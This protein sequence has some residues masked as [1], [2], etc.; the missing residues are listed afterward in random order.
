MFIVGFLSFV[1][2]F[3]QGLGV[4]YFDLMLTF[5]NIVKKADRFK[6]RVKVVQ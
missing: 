1:D 5:K 2:M 3:Y 4:W 6:N